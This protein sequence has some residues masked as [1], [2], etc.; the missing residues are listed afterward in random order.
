M[1]TAAHPLFSRLCGLILML[2]AWASWSS[3]SA[4]TYSVSQGGTV[5]D[6]DFYF[7]DSGFQL[8][9]GGANEDHTLTF[10][11]AHPFGLLSF[12]FL[13]FELTSGDE[14]EVWYDCEASGPPDETYSGTS[15]IGQYLFTPPNIDCITFRFTSGTVGGSNWLA[16]AQ[17]AMPCQAPLAAVTVNGATG[18][19]LEVCPNEALAF[20][21][22]PT[23][24]FNG[25]SGAWWNWDFGDGSGGA[26]GPTP[27][28]SYAYGGVYNVTLTVE[29]DNGCSSLNDLDIEIRVAAPITLDVPVL[30]TTI[31]EQ[32]GD[33]VRGCG[34]G[35]G[36]E[37]GHGR[38]RGRYFLPDTPGQEFTS[39]IT[40]S[41]YPTGQVVSS[42]DD[43]ESLLVN[44]EHSFLG[45]INMTLTC[46][47][48]NTL[49]VLN[50]TG[51]GVWLG[52]PVDNTYTRRGR[53]GYNYLWAP[54]GGTGT[55][56]DLF[57]VPAYISVSI[58]EGTYDVKA[59]GTA[60]SAV[61]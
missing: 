17:C 6:C 25:A 49:T 2:V 61:R 22:S 26:L 53:V 18:P 7:T 20:D 1:A 51:S 52:E 14:L 55:M 23:T 39:S 45:D 38:F 19:I 31:C 60:W 29:D 33:V 15:L 16:F 8:G 24:Y 46:P 56:T 28:K 40:F 12:Y 58:P 5:S 10:N 30:N 9:D 32:S 13:N 44:L 41:G 4:Q 59:I 3:I 27:T 34:Y 57:P 43:I 50:G 48:G 47:S 36:H 42:P 11:S 35:F 54:T 21:A 37:L